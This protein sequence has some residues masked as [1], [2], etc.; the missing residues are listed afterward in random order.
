M[1]DNDFLKEFGKNI[2]REQRHEASDADWE[3]LA[4]SLDAQ[5]GSNRRRRQMLAWVFPLVATSAFALL[6]AMLWQTRSESDAMQVEIA[7]L[8]AAVADQKSGSRVDTTL[9][10]ISVI[11]YDTIY[12]TVVLRTLLPGEAAPAVDSKSIAPIAVDISQKIKDQDFIGS[13]HE[14][15]SGNDPHADAL[16]TTQP[17]ASGHAANLPQ[18]EV[19]QP[20]AATKKGTD[21]LLNM[22]TSPVDEAKTQPDAAAL[23]QSPK[24]SISHP[25]GLYHL[26]LKSLPPLRSYLKQRLPNSSDLTVVLPASAPAPVPMIRRLRPRNVMVGITSGL[27]FPQTKGVEYHNNYTLG[28]TGQVALG[29][30]LL[31]VVGAEYGEANYK[32]S[33]F[34]SNEFKIPPLMRPTPNDALDH[35]ELKQPLLDFSLGLRHVFLPHKRLHP[36]VGAA[37]TMEQVQEERLRYEFRNQLTEE[38]TYVL[39][40]R[41]GSRFNAN[42]LQI[43]SGLEWA[44]AKRL[45]FRIEGMYQWQHAKS[46]P[47]LPERWGLRS[48]LGYRF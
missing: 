43:G 20:E 7:Q 13:R 39:V 40:Q 14:A 44:F 2:G 3:K 26:P 48:G 21:Q 8:R 11:R 12:R 46:V 19:S 9:R 38:A 32:V 6:G 16:P 47:L 45:S 35:V 23:D 5:A 1:N 33:G 4:F 25:D 27:L 24:P 15:V 10:H 42:G 28:L 30:Y 22:P 37:W 34:A 36:F 29:R 17:E 31:L 41:N 18:T